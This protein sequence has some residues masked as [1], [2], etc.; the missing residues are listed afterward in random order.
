MSKIA[1]NPF[2]HQKLNPKQQQLMPDNHNDTTTTVQIKYVS[3]TFAMFVFSL[4]K[5]MFLNSPPKNIHYK[6]VWPVDFLK[7]KSLV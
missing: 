5:L 2:H 6:T 7:T 1:E 3:F 4:L